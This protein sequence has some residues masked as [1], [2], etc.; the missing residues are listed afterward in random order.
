MRKIVVILALMLPLALSA[1]EIFPRHEFRA[2]WGDMGFEKAAFHNSQTYDDYRYA[3]HFFVGYRYSFLDW[4]GAGMDVDFSNVSWKTASDGSGHNFQN[5]SFIPSVRFTYYRK[6][7]VTMYSGIGAGLNINGGSETD[8]CGR[9][10]IC[11]AVYNINLYSI[12]LN[13]DKWFASFELS[14]LVSLNSKTE[15]FMFGSRLISFSI[16][17]RL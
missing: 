13:W 4:L 14:P 17:C 15:I 5:L 3:G 8:Y 1:Q 2:G 7:I 10:T 6:G 16:G 12:S 11:A 9:K